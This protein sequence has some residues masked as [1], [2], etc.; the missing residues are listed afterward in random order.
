MIKKLRGEK[1]SDERDIS[2]VLSDGAGPVLAYEKFVPLSYT[3]EGHTMFLGVSGSGKSRRGTIPMAISV[4]KH[5]ESGV[6]VDPKGEIYK[7]TKAMIP[8]D[9]EVHVIDFRNLN[10]KLSE[11][12][13]PLIMAYKLYISG[14]AEDRHAA[15]QI[16]EK[17]AASLYPPTPYNDPFWQNESRNLFIGAVYTLFEYGSEE[18]INLS[19]LYYI[20]LWGEEKFSVGE[21]YLKTFTE[22][23]G[24]GENA[25][26]Q[27]RSFVTTAN[28]TKGGIRSSFL[29]GLSVATKSAGV[30]NFLASNDMD[31][32]RITGDKKTLIYIIVPDE[33]PIYNDLAG[34]LTDQLATHYVNMAQKVYGGHLPV[35]VNIIIEEL[36]NVGRAL[37][38]L[39]FLMT[40]G[41]SRNIRL[42]FVLQ[43]LEQLDEIYGPGNGATIASNADCKV[44]Y[45]IHSYRTMEEYSRI[46]GERHI[47]IDGNLF[48]EAL[49]SPAKLSVMETGQ[50]LVLV[51]GKKL[52]YI[53]WLPDFTEMFDVPE[54][55]EVHFK[56]N[57][58]EHSRNTSVFD[59]REYV[60]EEKKKALLAAMRTGDKVDDEA[61]DQQAEMRANG[62][63]EEKKDWT[64]DSEP[65]REWRNRAGRGLIN[66][67]KGRV[68]QLE[69]E[70]AVGDGVSEG[71]SAVPEDEGHD[72]DVDELIR[73]IDER[74]KEL[75]EK[76]ACDTGGEEEEKPQDSET[77][78]ENDNDDDE[79]FFDISDLFRRIDE[80][81]AE[82][83]K[84]EVE[85]IEDE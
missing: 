68:M 57:K 2:R 84:K 82:L 27:L 3:G 43:S 77:D 52:K 22:L 61:E 24:V 35:R 63:E 66:V 72:Y 37:K 21:T 5:G 7:Y 50:A 4:I 74:I 48:K 55:D 60:R 30:R 71:G 36:G 51:S 56:E 8:E 12:W 32:S 11:G 9:Y 16:V 70:G 1:W 62:E 15:E 46:C 14:T 6:F 80:K 78:N 65:A 34:V 28:D 69:E 44:I 81:N 41:R 83:E 25:A 39:P 26:M 33:T 64:S 17:L 20:I 75:E 38:S 19:S 10:S 29:S 23:P 73:S 40:A 31:V 54:E 85:N 13:N 58:P 49:I 53:A 59:I 42:A 45:R 47:Y 76:G 18:D 67:L 79:E